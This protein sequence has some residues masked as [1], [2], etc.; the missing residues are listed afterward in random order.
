MRKNYNGIEMV[1]KCIL[2][3][4]QIEQK[5]EWIHLSHIVTDA[6]NS[7]SQPRHQRFAFRPAQLERVERCLQ[8][9]G[10]KRRAEQR[11]GTVTLAMNQDLYALIFVTSESNS[12][13]GRH[14]MPPLST[15]PPP[16]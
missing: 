13:F 1:F 11:Q 16:G 6:E 12:G 2:W 3:K 14:E 4:E 9:I 5:H 7:V 15:I 10:Q 8:I